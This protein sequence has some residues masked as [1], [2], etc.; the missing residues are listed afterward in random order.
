MREAEMEGKI[1]WVVRGVDKD[2]ARRFV[3]R[4]ASQR[5]PT[6][7]VLNEV[8]RAYLDR[9]ED[10]TLPAAVGAS[11]GSEAAADLEYLKGQI[12]LL[13][14]IQ[15][16]LARQ[17]ETTLKV[18]AMAE[19][20]NGRV[21]DLERPAEPQTSG[22]TSEPLVTGGEGTR[23]RLTPA[24]IA[25]VEQL[26]RVGAGDAEIAGLVGMDRGAIRQRRLKLTA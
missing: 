4:A 19:N 12:A 2:F 26:I 9:P 18:M 3:D 21:K 8:L 20:I 15:E 17:E 24:G 22:E 1:Q 10:P 23:R 6:G 7:D 25:E 14:A 16:R 13:Q 11:L 5:R